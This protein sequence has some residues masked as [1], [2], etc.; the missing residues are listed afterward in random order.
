MSRHGRPLW[1]QIQNGVS[2]FILRWGGELR[3]FLEVQQGSQTSRSFV[4]G[5]SEFHSSLCHVIS[6]Y[7]ELRGNMMSFRVTAGTSGFLSSFSR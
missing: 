5:N 1:S 7:V 6:P 4:T 2:G 3:L